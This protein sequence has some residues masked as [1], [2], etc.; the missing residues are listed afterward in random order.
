[1]DEYKGLTEIEVKRRME[2]YGL[3]EIKM[4]KSR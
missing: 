4:V 1:M 2:T 3:N